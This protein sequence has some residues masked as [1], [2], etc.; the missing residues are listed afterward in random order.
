MRIGARL[1]RAWRWRVRKLDFSRGCR[2]RIWREVAT[3]GLNLEVGLTTTVYFHRKRVTLSR[4]L[5]SGFR[6]ELWITVRG[7]SFALEWL[8]HGGGVMGCRE[9]S[10]K[11][12]CLRSYSKTSCS[13]I[14]PKFSDK[15]IDSHGVGSLQELIVLDEMTI[16]RRQSS[17][18]PL[19]IYTQIL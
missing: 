4:F 6:I 5:T 8:V 3:G 2:F 16:C 9:S 1:M 19:L 14:L 15:F 12:L 11:Q 18:K 7:G 10:Y 13:G 17:W